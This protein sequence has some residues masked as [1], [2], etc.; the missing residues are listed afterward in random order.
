MWIQASCSYS[1]GNWKQKKIT[2]RRWQISMRSFDKKQIKIKNIQRFEIQEKYMMTLI[3]LRFQIDL[4]KFMLPVSAQKPHP[5]DVQDEQS[6]NW[7][8][9][10]SCPKTVDKHRIDVKNNIVIKDDVDFIGNLIFLQFEN[11]YFSFWIRRFG[12]EIGKHIRK[13]KLNQ[14]Q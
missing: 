14:N 1:V 11:Q 6:L 7:E 4:Y 12:I 13:K 3:Q 9:I 10:W 5:F 2:L 8:H